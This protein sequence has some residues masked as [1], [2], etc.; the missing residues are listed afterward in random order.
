[1]AVV[2]GSVA[3]LGGSLS[4]ETQ[5]GL[6]TR[7]TIRLPLTLAIL[8]AVIIVA[9]GQTFAVPQLALREVIELPGVIRGPDRGEVIPYRG[10]ALPVVRLARLFGLPELLAGGP[11]YA[12]VVGYSASAVGLAVDRLAGQR[13]IV[14]RP[15]ND[16]L[17]KVPGIAGA[18]ELGD[19]RPVLILDAAALARL[20]A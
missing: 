14:V 12:L 1:M 19:G 16:P 10:G 6:G 15:V 20:A 17:V 11:R 13:E 5:P 3:G 4:L 18:T 7:F 9:A 8:D 2:S